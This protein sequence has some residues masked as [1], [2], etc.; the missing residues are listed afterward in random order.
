MNSSVWIGRMYDVL[1]ITCST[2]HLLLDVDQ[3]AVD[4]ADQTASLTEICGTV[5]PAMA[6]PV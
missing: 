5:K 6:S 2:A 1:L 3:K 4:F